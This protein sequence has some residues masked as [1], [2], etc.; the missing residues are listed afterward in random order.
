[1][2]NTFMPPWWA[3]SPHIQTILPV[4]TKVAKP[5]LQRQ[6]VELPDGDF[7]DLDWQDM[8]Q[9][10]KPIVIIIHGLEGSAQSHYARR[11]LQACKAQQ[12]AAVVH[13]H[14]SC[15]GEAN[16]L[17]RSYHSGDTDDLQFSLSTLKSAYPQSPLLA[18]GYSLGGNVLTKYQGEYQD[19]SLLARA[20]V[21]SAPLQLS[22]CA[23]RLENGFSKIYQ[24]HL[25]KQLRQKISHKL[26][27]PDLAIS[28]PLSRLEVERLNTFYEFDDKVTAPLHGFDGVDDY[29]ARASGL[30]FV[31]RITKPTLIIHAKDDPFMT[32]EVI[33]HS[34]QLSGYVE[35]ELHAYGGHVGFID[36]GTPWKPH[37]Y[38]E[39]RIL[40]FLMGEYNLEQ[41]SASPINRD[42]VAQ[43]N[44][45]AHSL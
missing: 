38:L 26:S 43:G 16:R 21:V 32:D 20:V 8:P 14:R 33:P 18:V 34:S 1:M 2:P 36:G 29:Y 45:D 42:A 4:F 15:S 39:R 19:D 44:T 31:S 25:I 9:A 6:R 35:Y 12:L 30:P 24:S 13:H 28:M 41:S 17:A 27:D 7:V 10:G 37:F 3:K 23:K 5:K 11:I 22:A 40:Q